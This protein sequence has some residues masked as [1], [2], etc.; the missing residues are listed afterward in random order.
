M[1]PPEKET[2][3]LAAVADLHC[4]RDG[5]ALQPLFAAAARAADILVLCGD[6]TDNGLPEEGQALVRALGGSSAKVPV[7]ALL[8]NHDYQSERQDEIRHIL[9]DVGINVLQGTTCEIYGIGFA[10]AKGFGGGFGDR[11]LQPWGEAP[12]KRFVREAVDES[13][14][15]ESA[16]AKL[17]T[18]IRFALLHYAP[19]RATVE[20]EP[21]EIYAFLGSSR[22]EEPITRYAVAGVFHGHAHRGTLEGRARGDVPVYNVSLPLLRR[23]FPN[24]PPFRLV[25]VKVPAANDDQA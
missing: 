11:A 19:I 18:S 8:G 5:Q 9:T 7:V 21:L 23:S 1:A 25:T 10:G 17:R 4:T 12:L 14:K 15:L 13:L 20:G 24:D 6:L 22:L 16:L 3:R 2:V